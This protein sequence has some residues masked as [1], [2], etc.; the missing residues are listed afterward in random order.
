MRRKG[1][2]HPR[3]PGGACPEA[4]TPAGADT[5]ALFQPPGTDCVGEQFF[6]KGG[7]ADESGVDEEASRDSANDVG[8]EKREGDMRHA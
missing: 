1:A 6:L 4:G 7:S 8:R 3:A 2:P 5:I